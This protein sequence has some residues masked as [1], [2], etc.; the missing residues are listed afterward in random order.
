MEE[1]A[2]VGGLSIYHVKTQSG[3]IIRATLANVDRLAEDHITW[4]DEVYLSWQPSAAVVL[5]C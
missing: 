5:T 4:E 1:I 2:Y 3:K